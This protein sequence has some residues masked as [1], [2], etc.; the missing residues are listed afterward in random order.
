MVRVTHP[1]LQPIKYRYK[2]SST[3][4]CYYTRIKKYSFPIHPGALRCQ[5]FAT[6]LLHLFGLSLISSLSHSAL[7]L[8]SKKHPC[9]RETSIGC[10]SQTPNPRFA[11]TQALA[12][13]RNQTHNISDVQ[14]NAPTK[15]VTWPDHHSYFILFFKDLLLLFYYSCLH[16][17]PLVLFLPAHPH[18]HSQLPHCCPC[19][20][21]IY[22][23]PLTRLFPFFPPLPLSLLP[24]GLCQFLLTL[25]DPLC[26]HGLQGNVLHVHVLV[27]LHV[28]EEN[29]IPFLLYVTL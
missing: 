28:L 15:W 16:F 17:S 25:V 24:S 11:T 8:D 13:T 19:P 14:N 4:F 10:L 22:T 3:V 2:I 21:A 26:A 1:I 27:L 12:L 23:C 29:Y 5:W 18:S 7:L 6:D 9:E 20:R